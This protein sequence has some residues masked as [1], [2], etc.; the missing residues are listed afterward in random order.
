MATKRK[1]KIIIGVSLIV[2]ACLLASGLYA[3]FEYY[4]IKKV[5]SPEPI[6]FVLDN[7]ISPLENQGLTLEILR[8]RHRG[9][10]EKLLNWGNSWKDKPKFY[11]IST[12]DGLEYISKNVQ[13]HGTQTE[14][15][16]NDWDTMFQENKIIKEVDE[17]N[18]T[19]MVTLTIIERVKS[20]ILGRKTSDVERDSFTVTYDYRTGRW[21]GDDDF[22]DYDGYGHYLGDTFEVW[23]NI[24]QFDIDDDFIPYW[25]EVNILG[26][27]PTLDDSKRDPDGDGIPTSWEWRWGYDPFTWDNHEKL[28]PD[29]DGIENIEEYQMAKWFANPFIQDIYIE[30]DSMG[31]TG[32]LD[33][34]HYL[35]EESMQG[36]IERFAEHNIRVYFD[37]GWVNGPANGG[38]DIVPHVER[39]SQDNG[40]ILQ[41]YNSYF[42][43]ERRGIFRYLVIG[44]LGGFSHTSENNIYDSIIIP[45]I[46]SRLNPKRIKDF[47]RLGWIPTERSNR[48]VIG[49]RLLHELGHSCSLNAENC[50]FWGIDNIT[51]GI[52]L[53]PKKA[54]MEKWGDNYRSVLNY[55]YMYKPY[56]F[57]LSDGSNGPPYDQNDW[58]MIFPGYFN[59]FNNNLIE[60]PYYNAGDERDIVE[61]EWRVTGYTYDANLTEKF[62]EYIA[63]YSPIDPI[64]VNWSVY[65]LSLIDK[66]KN[67]DKKDIKVFV[68]PKIK[69]TQQWLLYNEGDLDILGNMHFYSFDDILEEKTK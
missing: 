57:D 13:Q 44:H 32:L 62:V 12:M 59:F 27:D 39:V 46:S 47:V 31:G 60:E 2:I 67:P 11:F 61:S 58:S 38:G 48:V 55:Y 20:G 3:Y 21:H 10:L 51:Y 29:M 14:I 23:F 15:F 6:P 5:T 53:F 24:Y 43:E 22:K 16:F 9:L 49:A 50:N 28:D 17:E 68:Q 56:L 63:D 65:R 19:S 69:T 37:N 25:T 52:A 7:R 40:G 33:P 26:T 41:F 4:S 45:T 34:P 54:Y 35:Y 8:I 64:Q 36:V 18:E 1:Q 42:P 30:V 66:I